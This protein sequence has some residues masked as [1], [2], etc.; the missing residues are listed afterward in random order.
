MIFKNILLYNLNIKNIK[1]NKAIN[2]NNQELKT[3]KNSLQKYY[4]YSK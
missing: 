1:K 2:H 3:Y 4:K